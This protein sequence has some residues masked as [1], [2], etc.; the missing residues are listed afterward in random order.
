MLHFFIFFGFLA[1]NFILNLFKFIF[2]VSHCV[3]I[4]EI[5]SDFAEYRLL[6]VGSSRE[7]TVRPVAV[8]LESDAVEPL[9]ISIHGH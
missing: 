3:T 7:D 5:L 6:L 9:H 8:S 2:V 4:F 1:L